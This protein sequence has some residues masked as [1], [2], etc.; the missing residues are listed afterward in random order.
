V[1]AASG[2]SYSELIDRLIE[3]AR[4]RQADQ[5]RNRTRYER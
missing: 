1:W 2:V 5:A 3:L 4:R